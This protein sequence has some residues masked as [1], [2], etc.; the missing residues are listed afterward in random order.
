MQAKREKPMSEPNGPNETNDVPEPL[1]LDELRLQRLVIED[2]QLRTRAIL[3]CDPETDD[4]TL[5]MMD[6]E[7]RPRFSISLAYDGSGLSIIDAQGMMRLGIGQTSRTDG[8]RGISVVVF[9]AHARPLLSFG[10]RDGKAYFE[11]HNPLPL[12]I[13]QEL[14]DDPYSDSGQS[15]N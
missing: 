9:D 11:H 14:A 10:D 15:L 2:S 8:A 5:F 4:P 6:Q 3:T 7:G 13:P 12:R 1:R